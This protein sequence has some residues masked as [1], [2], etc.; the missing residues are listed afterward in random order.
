[1]LQG[2]QTIREQLA[3]SRDEFMEMGR[4]GAMYYQQGNLDKARTI[5]EGLV[6]LDPDSAD[7]HSALGALLTLKQEDEQAIE[8]LEAAV[9]LNPRQIAP[10]VNLGEIFIRQQRLEE[11][12]ANLR[13]AIELDPNE[14]DSGANR[15][16][17]MVLGIYEIIQVNG[18]SYER[19][20]Q[21]S[22]QIN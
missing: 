20:D 3:I 22:S 16:R 17:A 12:V 21:E 14:R 5:F 10:Y 19:I 18:H 4:V 7:A 13:K 2:H 1:M 11:A 6:E 15:A 8:H 9:A